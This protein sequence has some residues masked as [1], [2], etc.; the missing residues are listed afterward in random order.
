METS[1]S[2]TGDSTICAGVAGSG[3]TEIIEAVPK[4]MLSFGIASFLTEITG[5]LGRATSEDI[6]ERSSV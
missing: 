1:T 5:E 3:V 6:D 2:P 4:L